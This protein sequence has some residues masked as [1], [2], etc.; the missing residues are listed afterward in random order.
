MWPG[1]NIVRGIALRSD[2]LGGYVLDLYGGIHPFGNAP[3]LGGGPYWGGWD[4]ARGIVLRS[5]NAGGYMKMR[6]SGFWTPSL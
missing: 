5:D 1:Q 2:D 3:A 6:G 4:I